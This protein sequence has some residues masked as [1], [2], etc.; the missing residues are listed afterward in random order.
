VAAPLAAALLVTSCT[1]G[2]K[3]E[4]PEME[5]PPAHRG[6]PAETESIADVPWWQL[7]EDPV[8]QD[9]IREALA[10]NL[11]LRA[12]AARVEEVRALAGIPKSF[13]YPEVNVTAAYSVGQLSRR[14]D[15]PQASET[16]DRR[17]QNWDAGFALSWEIDIFGRLRRE[18]EAANAR[19]MATEEFR[20]GVIVTLVAD[21]ASGYFS[22]RDLDLQLEIARRTV[23]ANDETVAFYRRRLEG[24][25]SNRLELDQA[26][27]NRARTATAIPQIELQIA[28]AENALSV[29]LGRK[30][31]EIARGAALSDQYRP[32]RV[33]AGLPAQLLERR[34]D[35]VQAEHSLV[36]A[37]ADI[38]A[39][40]ALFF[41]TIS[42]TGFLGLSSR[43]LSD[44]LKSDGAVWSVTPGLFQP[45]FQAGRIRRNYEAAQARFEQSLAQYQQAALNSYR[46][47]ADA[48]AAIDNLAKARIEQE[49]GVEALRDASILSRSRYDT[50]LSNYLEILI[51]D[52]N[53]FDQELALARTRGDELTALTQ[54]YRA[55]GG[56]WQPEGGVESDTDR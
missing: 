14:S 28:V 29:L 50:G 54:L 33:P 44:M 3:Y 48:L 25:V 36:A 17:Y 53:L 23:E 5:P 19:Y 38:G 12:A 47:V 13:L 55:L 9:L 18:T 42:L 22:L 40:K 35:V 26:V 39:A 32:P 52:Q 4:R 46:E 21:V 45:L 10:N 11:D 20:R 6:A 27:A 43:S 7:F 24:G 8:L 51:A 31:G 16:G 56:G 30:P 41:P 1:L 34:P 37:N 49:A 15:P 2:P